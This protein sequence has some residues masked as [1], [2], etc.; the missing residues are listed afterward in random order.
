MIELS[1]RYA[2]YGGLDDLIAFVEATEDRARDLLSFAH[3]VAAIISQDNL[4][5]RLQGVDKDGQ[6]LEPIKDVTWELHEAFEGV[7]RMDG[8]PLAAREDGSATVLGFE[9]EVIEVDGP[10]HVV[11]TGDWPDLD[12]LKY[13][14]TGYTS[15]WGNPVPSRDICGLRPKAWWQIADEFTLWTDSILAGVDY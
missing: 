12:W 1:I 10:R 13:H 11:V 7:P 6:P 9:T 14:E 3:R 8:P 15:R 2:E 4:E 5:A